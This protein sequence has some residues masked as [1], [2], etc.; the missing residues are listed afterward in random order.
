[1][2]IRGVCS[3]ERFRFEVLGWKIGLRIGGFYVNEYRIGIYLGRSDSVEKGV[4]SGKRVGKDWVKRELE[5]F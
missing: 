4:G 2:R 1:M 3:R 5:V